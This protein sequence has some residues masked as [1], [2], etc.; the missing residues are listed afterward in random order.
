MV[1]T[2]RM[3]PPSVVCSSQPC[4]TA[5]VDSTKFKTCTIAGT[6]YKVG[7][8][9]GSGLGRTGGSGLGRTGT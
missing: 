6:E 8:G 2:A 5:S 7:R 1:T 4:G 9:K 3:A